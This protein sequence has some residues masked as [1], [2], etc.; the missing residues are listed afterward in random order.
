[1]V[2]LSPGCEMRNERL[3]KACWVY[4]LLTMKITQIPAR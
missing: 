1:M 3:H 2:L 4:A